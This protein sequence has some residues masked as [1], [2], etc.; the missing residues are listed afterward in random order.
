[1]TDNKQ[2]ALKQKEKN[3]QCTYISI[4]YDLEFLWSLETR[5]YITQTHKQTPED[6]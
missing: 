4:K 6:V 5:H 2:G 3:K 1:M